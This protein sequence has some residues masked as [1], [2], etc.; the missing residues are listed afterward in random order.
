[1]KQQMSLCITFHP[2][3]VPLAFGGVKEQRYSTILRICECLQFPPQNIWSTDAAPA[4]LNIFWGVRNVTLSSQTTTVKAKEQLYSFP[5]V[6]LD[7][8]DVQEPANI[9]HSAYKMIS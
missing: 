3:S 7:M 1:M 8:N 9:P 2:I 6:S 4:Y 5:E